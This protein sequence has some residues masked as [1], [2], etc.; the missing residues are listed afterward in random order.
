MAFVN[1]SLQK[2]KM[3][4]ASSV[5]NEQNS[6]LGAMETDQVLDLFDAPAAAPNKGSKK[7]SGKKMSRQALLAGV[8]ELEELS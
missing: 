7:K 4:I 8:G 1:N 5:V 6:N 3:N 2:F